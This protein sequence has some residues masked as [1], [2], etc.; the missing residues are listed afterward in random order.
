MHSQSR[1]R[2]LIQKYPV[3]KITVAIALAIAPWV[4]VAML[5]A[6]RHHAVGRT[7]IA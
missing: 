7:G 1:M 3:L 4:I 5:G 6:A 2:A